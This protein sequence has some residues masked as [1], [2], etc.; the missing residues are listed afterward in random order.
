MPDQEHKTIWEGNY[1]RLKVCGNWE[2]AER[3]NSPAGIVIIAVTPEGDL[4]LTEQYRVPMQKNVIE[5]PAGLSGD[6]HYGGEEFVETAR[7]ELREETGYEAAEWKQVTRPGPPSAGLSNELVVFFLARKLRRVGPGGGEGSEKIQV[8]HVPVSRVAEWL[9]EK[10]FG[11]VAI[12]PK[13]Y[14]GLY[15]LANTS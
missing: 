14:A 11:G 6:E 4:L 1:L 15:F 5:L 13:I 7:R 3:P 12:D 8:H 10:E 2:Y 9:H